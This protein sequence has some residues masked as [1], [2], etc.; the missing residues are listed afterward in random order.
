M[1][2]P[3][4]SVHLRQD[5]QSRCRWTA[6]RAN[7]CRT[8]V[9]FSVHL[10]LQAQHRWDGVRDLQAVPLR[11]SLGTSHFSNCQRLRRWGINKFAQGTHTV[12][13]GLLIDYFTQ[14][15][16]CSVLSSEQRRKCD[17]TPMVSNIRWPVLAVVRRP[18]AA[19]FE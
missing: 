16:Q 8:D 4:Q 17:D 13:R 14:S 5:G 10:R 6:G 15:A 12:V 1:Q 11:P 19:A 18:S 7:R 9:A 2:R 3:R